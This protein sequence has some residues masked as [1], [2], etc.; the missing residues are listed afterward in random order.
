MKLTALSRIEHDDQVFV[1][2]DMFTV[3]EEQATSL[4]RA[5]VALPL[6][7]SDGE[8]QEEA[9]AEPE[10]T[11]EQQPENM[12]EE[13]SNEEMTEPEEGEDSSRRGRKSKEA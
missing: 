13:V 6:E 7:G 1:A 4:I 2:G 11:V 5:G 8:V 3:S 10:E 12:V 9:P